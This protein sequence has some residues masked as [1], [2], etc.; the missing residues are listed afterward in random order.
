LTGA[1]GRGVGWGFTFG[2]RDRKRGKWKRAEKGEAR[3]GLGAL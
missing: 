1:G 3:V 2:L